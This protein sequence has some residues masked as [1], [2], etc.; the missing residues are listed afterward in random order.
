MS[1]H[2]RLGRDDPAP[3]LLASD[4]P[5][6]RWIALRWLA[7]SGVATLADVHAEVLADERTARLLD[8]L[9]AS[10]DEPAHVSGHDKPQLATNVLDL[11]AEFGLRADDD[12]RIGLLLEQ[13]LTHTDADDRFMAYAAQR[14]GPPVWGCL[15]CDTHAIADV[16]GRFGRA[17]DPRVLR[18]LAAAGAD[19]VHTDLGLAWGCRPD[20][21]TGFR[22]PGRASEP[23]PQ[24]TLEALRA[25]SW[26]P[27]AERPA[28]LAD[29]AHTSLEIWRQRGTRKPYMMGHGRQFKQVK[30]PPAWYGAYEVVDTLGR[31]P[32][33]WRHSSEDRASLAEIAAC[34]LAYNVAADGRVTP[35]SAF[36][37]WEW[38]SLGQKKEPSGLATAMVW[39]RLAALEELAD[40]IAAV[41][42]TRL[43][44]SKGGSGTPM[45][46]KV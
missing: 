7:D 21:A 5:Q 34:L 1:L 40:E 10:W 4:E 35:L 20:P 19:L 28:W 32:E 42:V 18:A 39:A 23:C 9:P 13:M 44:S 31:L 41:D 38:M 2:A 26:L 24:A 37:G 43:A 14:S 45:P 46:P 12:P 25:F 11:L 6:A 33:A 27:A 3:W 36:K 30:W 16:A 17:R 22:G 15:H 29:V 8:L